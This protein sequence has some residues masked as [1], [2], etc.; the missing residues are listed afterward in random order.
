MKQRH[1][2][3]NYQQ[4]HRIP[5]ANARLQVQFKFLLEVTVTLTFDLM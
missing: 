5:G 2:G 3:N 1:G 4:E